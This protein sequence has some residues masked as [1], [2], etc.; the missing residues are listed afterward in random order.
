[1][2][3]GSSRFALDALRDGHQHGLEQMRRLEEVAAAAEEPGDGG[4]RWAFDFFHGDM[5]RHFREEEQVLFPALARYI[6]WPG[7]L[8]AMM[9]EH[10][11]LWKAID[12][13]EKADN[14]TRTSNVARHIVWLLRSHIEKEDT[15][16]LPLAERTLNANELVEVGR[17]MEAPDRRDP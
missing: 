7:V 15:V 13:L 6:G 12:A 4:L 11:S 2:T 16:L 17:Q 8:H 14:P 3:V 10:R 5:E 9:E 1:M